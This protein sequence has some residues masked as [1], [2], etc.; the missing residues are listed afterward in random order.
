MASKKSNAENEI[1]DN[2]CHSVGGENLA[3]MPN[4]MTIKDESELDGSNSSRRC[5][6]NWSTVPL[7]LIYFIFNGG[8]ILVW[9]FIPNYLLSLGW[10]S[11][12]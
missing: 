5:S 3:F 11:A 9:P 10:K 8:M 6:I 12:S 2:F 1:K 4:G 7:K